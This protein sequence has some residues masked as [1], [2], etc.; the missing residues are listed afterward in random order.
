MVTD[1]C[2]YITL[3]FFITLGCE[4]L[5]SVSMIKFLA[6]CLEAIGQQCN[7]MKASEYLSDQSYHLQAVTNTNTSLT[8]IFNTTHNP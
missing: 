7:L 4:F 6:T 5:I 3:I 2:K 8:H 1:F